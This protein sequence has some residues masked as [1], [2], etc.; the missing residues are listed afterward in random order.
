MANSS[1]PPLHRSPSLREVDSYQI[2]LISGNAHPALANEI[3]AYMRLPLTRATAGRFS[4]GEIRVQIDE[5]VRGADVFVIQP[6]CKPTNDNLMELLILLDALKR[7]SA[8]RITAVIPYYGYARQD[9]KTQSRAPITSKLVADLITQ[10]GAQRV[11]TMELH[12]GQIQGFFNIPVD[13]LFSGSVLADYFLTKC[14]ERTCVV[15]P[16]A[17]GIE[18]ARILA[19]KLNAG[20]AAIDKR[21]DKPNQATAMHLVGD[22]RNRDCIIFDDMIDTAGTIVECVHT[23]KNAGALRV[24]ACATHGVLSGPAIDRLRSIPLEEIVIT[25]TIPLPGDKHLP[26]LVILSIGEIMANAIARIHADESLLE[27]EPWPSSPSPSLPSASP[28]ELSPGAPGPVC[29]PI[30]GAGTT[31]T[32]PTGDSDTVS[33]P[34]GPGAPGESSRG[35]AEGSE[36]EGE[37]WSQSARAPRRPVPSWVR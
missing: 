1:H 26:N 20:L 22:V 10:A 28:R 32:P 34:T 8:R 36:G 18:R 23:L 33:P 4:D 25:N 19:K 5:N 31:V 35:E 29:V 30:P 27:A 7:S 15:S 2:K 12:A 11:L 6:T 13:H 17:G 16:D 14:L 9:R 37:D 24:F 21:R 3:A